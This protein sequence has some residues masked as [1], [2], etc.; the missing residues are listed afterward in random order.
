MVDS[1]HGKSLVVDN[2]GREEEQEADNYREMTVVPHSYDQEKEQQAD[3]YRETME[4]L[5]SYDQ[6]MALH[7]CVHIEARWPGRRW[8]SHRQAVSRRSQ[9]WCYVQAV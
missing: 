7:S 2:Y 5:H 8:I 4:V 6:A 9:S 1:C 3:N